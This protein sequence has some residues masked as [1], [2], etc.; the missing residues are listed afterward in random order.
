MSRPNDAGISHKQNPLANLDRFFTETLERSGSEKHSY[1]GMF[2]QTN[3][4][5]GFGQAGCRHNLFLIVTPL[6]VP[7]RAG[8]V[9]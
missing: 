2:F 3:E 1:V 7:I 9:W 6:Q 5:I 4:G 8:V